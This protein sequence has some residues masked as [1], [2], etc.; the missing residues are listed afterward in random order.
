MRRR[1]I[2]RKFTSVTLWVLKDNLRAVQFYRAAGFDE[3]PGSETEII[4]SDQKLREVR[5]AASLS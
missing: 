3:D 4:R 2:E 1:L 5:Y